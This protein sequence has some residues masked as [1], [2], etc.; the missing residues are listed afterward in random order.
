MLASLAALALSGLAF[1][2]S[3]CL[4]YDS[5]PR[6]SLVLP[7]GGAWEEGQAV[8]INFSEPINVDTLKMRIWEDVRD[9]E[10]QLPASAAP[11]VDN[12]TVGSCGE[13]VVALSEDRTGLSLVLPT[14]G[15]GKAGKPLLLQLMSGLEDGEG[16]PTGSAPLFTLQF[17]VPEEEEGCKNLEPVQFDSGTFI[18]GA[19]VTKPLPAIL[20][21]ISDVKVTADGTFVLVGAEGDEIMGASKNTL[22]PDELFVDETKLGFTLYVKGKVCQRD[23]QRLL[24]TDIFNVRIPLGDITVVLS[25]VRLVAEIKKDEA[26]AKDKIEG[27]LSFEAA[28]LIRGARTTN[29]AGGNTPLV[30]VFVPAEKRPEGTPE[31]CGDLCGAVEL[32]LCE[33]P[34]GFPGAG[35]CE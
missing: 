8:L 5:P 28:Q 20:T 11:L 21:L 6:A 25:N 30:G 32:G 35:V 18:L 12:C 17:R 2:G 16:N 23:A 29:L 31:L 3:G 4:A 26:T 24:E 27:T 7:E 14:D 19:S 13:V 22:N 9:I 33:P 34:E 15:I 1:T 10:G